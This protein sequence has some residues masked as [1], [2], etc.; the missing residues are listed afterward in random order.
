MN[1]F[2]DL[3][4]VVEGLT[5]DLLTGPAPEKSTTLVTRFGLMF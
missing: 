2:L 4:Q 5:V 3:N 1:R